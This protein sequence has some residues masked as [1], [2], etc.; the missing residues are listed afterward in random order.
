MSVVVSPWR[1]RKSKGEW[2]LLPQMIAFFAQYD[3]T[4]RAMLEGILAMEEEHAVELSDL[5]D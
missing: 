2:R 4:T 5:L 3:P 1:P